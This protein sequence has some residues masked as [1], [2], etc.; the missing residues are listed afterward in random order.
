MTDNAVEDIEESLEAS[1]LGEE[2]LSLILSKLSEMFLTRL[3]K[4]ITKL[5]G[6]VTVSVAIVGGE[7]IFAEERKNLFPIFLIGV[8]IQDSS[9][10][11]RRN[12]Y[13]YFYI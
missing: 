6:K 10:R 4:S 8:T 1:L 5:V 13:K 2:V 12:V 11:E 9:S 3:T 7:I